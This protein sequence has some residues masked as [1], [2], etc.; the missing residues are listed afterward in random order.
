MGRKKYI[1]SGPVIEKA[2]DNLEVVYREY[3]KYIGLNVKIYN[4]PEEISKILL[5]AYKAE[6]ALR[7]KGVSLMNF[8]SLISD[9]WLN[10]G[11]YLARYGF[12]AYKDGKNGGYWG[13]CYDGNYSKPDV[14]QFLRKSLKYSLNR[15]LN[16][17]SVLI[18][19]FLTNKIEFEVRRYVDHYSI[20]I[21]PKER[22]SDAWKKVKDKI[23]S[24]EDLE[25][26]WL[27]IANLCKK[28][29]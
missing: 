20:N 9:I 1:I 15:S 7:Y 27:V 19:L 10:F 12:V 13:V 26:R 23:L 29:M 24:D 22:E 14:V 17:E 8:T 3:I 25:S 21:E 5:Q 16:N 2:V 6:N 4:F 18:L 28:L 11:N